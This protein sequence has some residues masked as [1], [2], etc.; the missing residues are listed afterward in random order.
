MTP[1]VQPFTLPPMEAPAGIVL[2]AGRSSR[3]GRAK[4]TVE[5][6]GR[7]FLERAIAALQACSSTLVVLAPGDAVVA[8]AA[9]RLGA[10]AVVNPEPERGMLSSIAVGLRAAESAWAFVLPVDCPAVRP[11][12]VALLAASRR[13]TRKCAAVVPDFAGRGGHPILLGPEVAAAAARAVAGGQH[14]SLERLLEGVPVVRVPVQDPGVLDNVNSPE[15]L[16]LL[17]R[18]LTFRETP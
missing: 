18:R 3:M 2:A 6:A 16:A 13:G 1:A 8:A 5:A 17:L 11:D 15:D 12:T 7:T 10:R 4:A 9:T 14:I